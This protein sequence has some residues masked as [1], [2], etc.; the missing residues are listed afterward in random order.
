MY[1]GLH[2]S[3]MNF[4]IY[5]YTSRI[6]VRVRS[7]EHEFW[8]GAGLRR[9]HCCRTVFA[10]VS[11][12][13]RHHKHIIVT[14]RFLY[15][16]IHITVNTSISFKVLLTFAFDHYSLIAPVRWNSSPDNNTLINTIYKVKISQN[17]RD[18]EHPFVGL[19]RSMR[20]PI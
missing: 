17:T 7:F 11:N 13:S 15:Y 2:T 3:H 8:L 14:L 6:T 12:P 5:T 19:G 20:H 9:L 10:A 16:E 1:S 4:N 18:N